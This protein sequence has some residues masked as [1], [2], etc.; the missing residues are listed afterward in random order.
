MWTNRDFVH[1]KKSDRLLV[2][3]Q[4]ISTYLLIIVVI[5]FFSFSVIA[6]VG[7]PVALGVYDSVHLPIFLRFPVLK[8]EEFFYFFCVGFLNSTIIKSAKFCIQNIC[9]RL[10]NKKFLFITS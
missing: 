1:L 3:W 6:G 8:Q 10:K 2:T 7:L 5:L 9:Q 4:K